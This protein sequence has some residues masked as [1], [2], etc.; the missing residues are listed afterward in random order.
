M[1]AQRPFTI[2]RA[3]PPLGQCVNRLIN[4]PCQAARHPQH[5][6]I[7]SSLSLQLELAFA[8]VTT[9]ASQPSSAIEREK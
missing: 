1:D 9:T 7:R 8:K 4:E 3:S 6:L 2:Q 5:P